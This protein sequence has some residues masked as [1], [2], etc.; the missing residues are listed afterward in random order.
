[1]F[2]YD[3][4]T[5]LVTCCNLAGGLY[6]ITFKEQSYTIDRILYED[7]RG[8]AQYNDNYVLASSTNG[9]LLLNN[10][11]YETKRNQPEADLD[12]HGV[13]VHDGKAYIVETS[14]NTIGIYSLPDL[15]RIGEI[16]IS[17][18]ETNTK[19]IND[20]CII[21]KS[22]YLTMFCKHGEWREATTFSGVLMEYSLIDDK[23]PKTHFSWLKQPHSVVVD[24]GRILY[25]NS[26]GFE[27]KEN[28]NVIFCGLGYTRGLATK[29]DLLYIGQS[30]S[31]HFEV[32]LEKRTNISLDCGIHVF[33]YK[34]KL[35]RFI[36]LPSEEVYGILVIK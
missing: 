29:N 15:I 10:N 24:N 21:N 28:A 12:F 30:Q 4:C 17:P 26:A 32:L 1:M 6:R 31:R 11:L 5:V 27:V 7:C 34:Q 19:H 18:E 36:P 22:I 8:I 25:C 14:R 16:N 9:I 33:N 35:S 23:P 2:Q 13:A 20:I 3:D